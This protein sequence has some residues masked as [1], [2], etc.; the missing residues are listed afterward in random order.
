MND[1]L[2][3][4][5]QREVNVL[6]RDTDNFLA[7]FQDQPDL[8]DL[9]DAARRVLATAAALFY[10]RG[11]AA[12][13]VRDVTQ[14]CGLSPG[15]LY[16]HFASKDDLLYTLV[17]HGQARMQWHL[18]E[19]FA[20]HPPSPQERFAAFVQAY[21]V[22]HLVGPQLAQV[23]RREY[24]HL[25]PARRAEVTAQRRGIRQQ[26]AEI[27]RDGARSGAFTLIGGED[28]ATGTAL[29]VLDMCSRTSDWFD[30]HGPV[31]VAEMAQR[32]VL[33]AQRLVGARPPRVRSARATL[34]PR[35][36]R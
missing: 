27:L 3:P 14:A 21:V 35:A 22:A 16:N 2:Y 18:D 13:S 19:A 1:R 5:A 6:A 29:M 12:T 23:T 15:A 36:R 28:G 34:R 8:T 9:G 11:A 32:Y 10:Q 4:P 20:T 33:A 30:P 7:A 17:R 26:L 31:D 25:S 24:L